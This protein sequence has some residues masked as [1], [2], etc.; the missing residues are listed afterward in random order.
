MKNLDLCSPLSTPIEKTPPEI[1]S[2]IF[3]LLVPRFFSQIPIPTLQD[4]LATLNIFTNVN[5]RWRDIAISD[6]ILWK[7]LDLTSKRQRSQLATCILRRWIRNMQMDNLYLSINTPFTIESRQ[8]LIN[9]YKELDMST[10]MVKLHIVIRHTFPQYHLHVLSGI[11]MPN[12][13]S[14]AITEQSGFKSSFSANV[15]LTLKAPRLTELTLNSAHIRTIPHS[16]TLQQITKLKI[17]IITY[18]LSTYHNIL[19]ACP[20][21]TDCFIAISQKI[22]DMVWKAGQFAVT[23]SHLKIL[24]I[25]ANLAMVALLSK[26]DTPAL[27][28]LNISVPLDSKVKATSLLPFIQRAPTIGHIAATGVHITKE[29]DNFEHNIKFTHP[30]IVIIW[31]ETKRIQRIIYQE[32]YISGNDTEPDFMEDSQDQGE[33][34]W[35][36]DDIM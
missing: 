15:Q 32:E 21:L 34:G 23:L 19:K 22:K 14:L 17:E 10:R 6:P 20:L 11:T 29:Q 33:M 7:R 9:L 31:K 27:Q 13:E 24:S 35:E 8:Y 5:K 4:W 36:S 3:R 16:Q 28:V 1:I 18:H 30:D 25:E 26:I 2:L 12:L